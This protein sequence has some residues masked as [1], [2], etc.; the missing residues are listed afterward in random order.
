MREFNDIDTQDQFASAEARYAWRD[1]V[2]QGR[3]FCVDIDGVLASI[4]KDNNYLF[5]QPLTDNIRRV[6]RLYAAGNRIILFTA[7][8]SMTGFDWGE[9]TRRQMQEWGV[10]H[11]ELHFG[12]PAADYY[13]DDRMLSIAALQELDNVNP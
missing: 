9:V 13:I 12:K 8:G 11:H 6:N 3:V 5:S 7:R 10:S 2:P 4:T 1:G